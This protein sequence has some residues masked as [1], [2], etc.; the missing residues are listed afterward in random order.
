[1][2]WA[3]LPFRN[4]DPC[5]QVIEFFDSEISK[6]DLTDALAAL[7]RQGFVEIGYEPLDDAIDETYQQKKYL[8][9]AIRA[10]CACNRKIKYLKVE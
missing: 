2:N 9:Q 5:D 1:M 4:E 10:V 6:E 3:E 8:V 7:S